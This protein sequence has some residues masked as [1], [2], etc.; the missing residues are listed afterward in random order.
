MVSGWRQ[1]VRQYPQLTQCRATAACSGIEHIRL[2]AV[3]L[4]Q[5]MATGPLVGK[6]LLFPLAQAVQALHDLEQRLEAQMA[7]AGAAHQHQLQARFW[8]A[9][10]MVHL[11]PRLVD[12]LCCYGGFA[13]RWLS[14]TCWVGECKA[15][16]PS[17]AHSAGA[18]KWSWCFLTRTP[19]VR[20]EDVGDSDACFRQQD[21]EAALRQHQAGQDAAAHRANDAQT[22]SAVGKSLECGEKS[23]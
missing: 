13:Y 18:G 21:L 8:R 12:C 3:A 17:Q 2:L 11:K 22:R 16:R 9:T 1:Q 5:T 10:P 6:N 20:D 14:C 19:A 4:L 7:D 23:P 15:L